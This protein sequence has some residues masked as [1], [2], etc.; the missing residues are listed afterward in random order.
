M[1]V[2]NSRENSV[3]GN[4][5]SSGISISESRN[6][7]PSGNDDGSFIDDNNV[8]ED[9][10]LT[11]MDDEENMNGRRKNK[12]NRSNDNENK[13]L[14]ERVQVRNEGDSRLSGSHN[15]PHNDLLSDFQLNRSSSN[16]RNTALNNAS[17]IAMSSAMNNNS[18]STTIN[19]NRTS[20]NGGNS[21][22]VN[23]LSPF[24][25]HVELNGHISQDMAH[26]VRN[27]IDNEIE[28]VDMDDDRL[29]HDFVEIEDIPEVAEVVEVD[30]LEEVE[31]MEVLSNEE[32]DENELANVVQVLERETEQQRIERIINEE[33]AKRHNSNLEGIIFINNSN[34]GDVSSQ[35]NG[36]IVASAP[37]NMINC[38]GSNSNSALQ[39]STLK[40]TPAEAEFLE[41]LTQHLQ[42]ELTCPIC[43]DY[44]YLPVTMNCGH[45]FCRY[46]IGHNKLHGKNCP[47][48]RQTLGNSSCINTVISNLVRIYNL[49]RKALKVYKSVE[50]VN[51]VD[52]AWWNDN[53][54][55]P[56]ITVPL[57]LRI[58]L[59]DMISPAVFFDDLTSCV[60][61]FFTSNNLWSMSKWVFNIND[62]KIFSELIGYDKEDKE[63]T[64]E[65]LHSW[66]ERYITDHPSLCIRKE[67]K[68]ILKLF[69]DR[70]H[71]IDSHIFDSS[72]LPNR[73]PWDGGRH[74]KSLIHMPHSSVSL[75]HLLFV[76][77][78]NNNIG[79][80]D[81]G[82]TI[83]TMIKVNDYHILKE[84]DI[85]H[86][87]DRIEVTVSIDSNT[88][89]M[90][91]K[92]YVWNKHSNKVLDRHELKE[93]V[94]MEGDGD[95]QD[96][97]SWNFTG[98]GSGNDNSSSNQDAFVP[99]ERI[100]SYCEIIETNLLIKFD[101][102]MTKEDTT[103]KKEYIDPK[104]VVLGRGPYAQSSY[105]KVPVTNSNGYVSREH[106]LIYY[107]GS[108]PSGERWLL[109]DTSTLGTFLK[110]KP[111]T[112]PIPLPIGSI[113]KAGQC[114]IEVCSQ[115][116][117]DL[118]HL[119][120]GSNSLN[121]TNDNPSNT[122]ND[123]NGGGDNRNNDDDSNNTNN[124]SHGSG[125]SGDNGN[126]HGGSGGMG[127]SGDNGNHHGGSGNNYGG[128]GGGNYFGRS[129]NYYRGRGNYFGR[130]NNYRGGINN[131]S[132]VG[133][134]YLDR[135]TNYSGVGMNHL[136]RNS[137]Y[138]GNSSGYVSSGNNRSGSANNEG[139][140]H[141]GSRVSP[142]YYSISRNMNRGGGSGRGNSGSSSNIRTVSSSNNL[143][144]SNLFSVANSSANTSSN[145]RH[146]MLRRGNNLNT[147]FVQGFTQ[148]NGQRALRNENRGTNNSTSQ[149]HGDTYFYNYLRH[150]ANDNE[151]SDSN[152][153][154]DNDS[155][156]NNS[157]GRSN[158]RNGHV[159][160]GDNDSTSG[161]FGR[162]GNFTS[163]ANS[164]S[165]NRAT[166]SSNR[167]T[168]SSNHATDN[169]NRATDNSSRDTDNS[170]GSVNSSSGG[171]SSLARENNSR[172]VTNVRVVSS[173]SSSS[174]YSNPHFNDPDLI[175]SLNLYCPMSNNTRRFSRSN[176]EHLNQR[177]MEHYYN[178]TRARNV[179]ELFS[180]N[181]S[182]RTN[183]GS[184]SGSVNDSANSANSS[185]RS[186][187]NPSGGVGENRSNCFIGI[188]NERNSVRKITVENSNYKY[189]NTVVNSGA[190]TIVGLGTVNTVS[191]VNGNVN[192]LGGV[193]GSSS[194]GGMRS[195]SGS[196]NLVSFRNV[197]GL[198]GASV[199]GALI[200]NSMSG[201]NLVANSVMTNS[202][203]PNRVVAN[204]MS[205]ISPMINHIR[206]ISPIA[207]NNNGISTIGNNTM[208]SSTTMTNSM[209]GNNANRS[210][211]R[212]IPP[213][214]SSQVSFIENCKRYHRNY[215][216]A[217]CVN[218]NMINSYKN[219]NLNI[220]TFFHKL[221]TE[222]EREREMVRARAREREGQREMGRERQRE[223][224][225]ERQR[226]EG[227][228]ERERERQ[229]EGHRE[230]GRERQ[231]E[232][233]RERERERQ[234]EGH[235][236]RERERHRER[237]RRNEVPQNNQYTGS[238]NVIP[239]NSMYFV[240]LNRRESIKR[241]E[242]RS[243]Y[244]YISRDNNAERVEVEHPYK[245]CNS[246]IISSN[247][248]SKISSNFSSSFSCN[249]RDS[250][251]SH[252]SNIPNSNIRG[253]TNDNTSSS[254]RGIPGCLL[255]DNVGSST[256][257]GISDNVVIAP[258]DNGSSSIRDPP[259]ICRL[260]GNVRSCP[261]NDI[262]SNVAVVPNDSSSSSIRDPPPNC[263]FFGNVNSP[264]D[265]T[266]IRD[267]PGCYASGASRN[268]RCDVR[269]V[270]SRDF[271]SEIRSC[272][273]YSHSNSIDMYS[274]SGSSGSN[275]NS[276]SS[277][278]QNRNTNTIKK[279]RN[280][281]EMF[282][283]SQQTTIK[284]EIEEQEINSRNSISS[285]NST[286]LYNDVETYKMF[287][288]YM[289]S[290]NLINNINDTNHSN[291]DP[292]PNFDFEYLNN[293][294]QSPVRTN[295]MHPLNLFSCDKRTQQDEGNNTNEE[296]VSQE[297]VRTI[298][299]LRRERDNMK[300]SKFFN[301]T[302]RNDN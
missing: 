132:D 279:K 186:I 213:G 235:R 133:N 228:R 129:N 93:L 160:I 21:A 294:N 135:S 230:R 40:L 248:S 26:S 137:N 184:S 33:R 2:T 111:F 188:N 156:T 113:F 220:G 61:D 127:D 265:S 153:S 201:S 170:S 123:N 5:N 149:N 145:R 282:S 165:G 300:N 278:N 39:L 79:V 53:F 3:R 222:E 299:V 214:N 92:G 18:N 63:T 229:R 62:C 224:G 257:N 78:E 239:R 217:F 24:N 57:F 250:T 142:N 110:V 75:S 231:R 102:G 125:D 14:V 121:N 226:E 90:P 154:S 290:M 163:D 4:M 65:R 162:G 301:P 267:P 72:V 56:Q 31:E 114:K 116:T 83:G 177:I 27:N 221:N 150:S 210:S 7:N 247:F 183:R 271:M 286:S 89:G 60:I 251:S 260:I 134:N 242:I 22:I 131:Y 244:S 28:I 285:S 197:T 174:A 195:V 68:I 30:D 179:N 176:N 47:L 203:D 277:S 122:D 274:S 298:N 120:D 13:D 264:N 159:I 103:L 249:L 46:C 194:I 164:G 212:N 76:K 86:I 94:K 51:T 85:I 240:S 136:G 157:S 291:N 254:V 191:G 284:E 8:I 143:F 202:I 187:C 273:T 219:V 276:G 297:E 124:N 205:T 200:A 199:V 118:T 141:S 87:G 15:R 215:D 12:N 169:S 67:E 36:I 252:P 293:L 208:F 74:V 173:S 268:P 58:F 241:H 289:D 77:V 161:N 269:S 80:V 233:H 172:G 185:N 101:F 171:S 84:G 139:N 263:L 256:S 112:D 104:G 147:T 206:D 64:N 258:N 32:P 59:Y 192:D 43:L 262:N 152:E 130:S 155:G 41:G 181:E 17:H 189:E 69:Q 175:N 238:S 261:S 34:S 196:N 253:S 236:E 207:N 281:A 88:A 52:E 105:K 73:L 10:C 45:T 50:V 20:N 107:D 106:C 117:A 292:I 6:N 151:R 227:H 166:G 180:L 71:R 48:C 246:G 81:C 108:K 98:N 243:S 211:S 198:G 100:P 49:R 148:N 66:V 216:T 178:L 259:P 190:S 146:T 234:R 91:Y 35:N 115:E 270:F 38:S 25:D 97:R 109:R 287:C 266:S 1:D 140:V 193:N 223:M 16:T 167:A 272:T 82:S 9:Q 232:G 296:N 302:E 70:T 144:Y 255:R 158:R 275:G 19:D 42:R 128:G 288:D 44:F 54:I 23:A 29:V 204:S 237:Q 209:N 245:K 55:K 283:Y 126:N 99:E 138:S 225:R 37:N 11:P 280:H 96:D 182:S 119:P 168:D 218:N 295:E 95:D